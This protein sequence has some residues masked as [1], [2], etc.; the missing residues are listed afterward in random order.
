MMRF[1]NFDSP[2]LL[3]VFAHLAMFNED[4]QKQLAARALVKAA[5]ETTDWSA[6][7]KYIE[8]AG[9]VIV[10]Q[11]GVELQDVADDLKREVQAGDDYFAEISANEK[12]WITEGKDVEAE[13][14]KVYFQEPSELTVA[15]AK[16]QLFLDRLFSVPNFLL[17]SVVFVGAWVFIKY[18]RA[19]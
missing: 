16:R 15:T 5:L 9:K 6:K 18:R 17:L 8:M 7:E 2:I 14:A 4:Q 1:G 13:Y 19:K 3:E 10:L 12:A 11:S